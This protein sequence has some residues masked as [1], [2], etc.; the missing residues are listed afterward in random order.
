MFPQELV[1]PNTALVSPHQAAGVRAAQQLLQPQVGLGIFGDVEIV[2][3][4]RLDAPGSDA[5]IAADADVRRIAKFLATEFRALLMLAG[6]G[7]AL[8]EI[9]NHVEVALRVLG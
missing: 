1:F 3:E 2:Q 8:R 6:G 4:R 7:V 9:E 5:K